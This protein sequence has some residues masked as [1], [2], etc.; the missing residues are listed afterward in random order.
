MREAYA[1]VCSCSWTLPLFSPPFRNNLW[2]FFKKTLEIWILYLPVLFNCSEYLSF[3]VKYLFLKK[4]V[5]EIG[6]LSWNSWRYANQEIWSR[7]E[8]APKFNRGK[9]TLFA[10][11]LNDNKLTAYWA[12]TVP[13]TSVKDR[14]S[15]TRVAVVNFD[16]QAFIRALKS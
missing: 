7:E 11:Q 15:K 6:L 13:N 4:S 14:D 8:E 5:T 16:L 3:W 12:S 9:V 2:H 10:S 1:K